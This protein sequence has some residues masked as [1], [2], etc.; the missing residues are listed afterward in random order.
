MKFTLPKNRFIVCGI[1]LALTFFSIGAIW[2][3]PVLVLNSNCMSDHSYNLYWDSGKFR[4]QYKHD[5][6]AYMYIGM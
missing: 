1:C 4:I 6:A 3:N 5:R 2:T